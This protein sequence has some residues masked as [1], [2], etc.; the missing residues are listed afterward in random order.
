MKTRKTFISIFDWKFVALLLGILLVGLSVFVLNQKV[1]YRSSAFSGCA[2]TYE[3]CKKDC[4]DE[5]RGG[6]GSVADDSPGGT[7]WHN[8]CVNNCR[9]AKVA[10]Q[11][12]QTPA[13]QQTQQQAPANQPTGR[14]FWFGM[15]TSP[16]NCA[17]FNLTSCTQNCGNNGLCLRI[18]SAIAGIC[19]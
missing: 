11:Q 14:S 10:C 7:G 18:C 9:R 12:E 16:L 6:Y 3:S 8:L 2:A 5:P 15:G 13:Q 19:Q 4:E 17:N 1:T